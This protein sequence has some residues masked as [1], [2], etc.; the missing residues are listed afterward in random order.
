[1]SD[2]V[3]GSIQNMDF[4]RW[5]TAELGSFIKR[6]PTVLIPQGFSY[7]TVFNAW[8][9]RLGLPIAKKTAD[10][11]G[12]PYCSLHNWAK[13]GAIPCLRQTLSLCWCFQL[14][15][16][17]FLLQHVPAGHDGMVRSPPEQRPRA[18]KVSGRRPIDKKIL[19][20]QLR[21]IVDRNKYPLLPFA[22]ICSEKLNRKP[23]VVRQIY[24][25]LARLIGS[26]FKKRRHLIAARKKAAYCAEIK[27]TALELHKMGVIPNH[28]TLASFMDSP[29]RMRSEWAITALKE[30]RIQLG[31]DLLSEQL[32]LAV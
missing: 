3:A 32:L 23:A 19:E 2:S 13:A 24:P 12:V 5:V 11:I 6:Q 31:Y 8:M 14:S 25:E 15:L 22:Q 20:Q 7:P 30:V 10:L 17:D 4:E 1:M 26:R 18:N 28:K 27:E 29:G 9:E 21:D 16:E